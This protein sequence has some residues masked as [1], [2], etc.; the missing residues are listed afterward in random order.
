[1]NV[2][3]DGTFHESTAA[4]SVTHLQTGEIRQ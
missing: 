1:M 3:K 2:L 4:I